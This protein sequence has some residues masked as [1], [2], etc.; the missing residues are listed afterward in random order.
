[1]SKLVGV[2]LSGAAIFA[3][4]KMVAV[5]TQ[6]ESGFHPHRNEQAARVA[7]ELLESA[8]LGWFEKTF[9]ISVGA[10]LEQKQQRNAGGGAARPCRV[11]FSRSQP[12]ADGFSDEGPR[13]HEA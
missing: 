11:P 8:A 9:G 13:P 12:Q 2:Q 6:G 5:Q 7:G 3:I 1:M 10:Y 4:K